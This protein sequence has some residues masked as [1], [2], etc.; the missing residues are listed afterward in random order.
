[1]DTSHAPPGAAAEEKP[2]ETRRSPARTGQR[3]SREMTATPS[4]LAGALS[5]VGSV[6]TVVGPTTIITGLLFWFGYVATAA[7]F[8]YFGLTLDL[9]NLSTPDL[10]LYGVEVIYVPIIGAF[11]GGLI[12]VL[13]HAAVTWVARKPDRDVISRWIAALAG[14]SGVMMLLR[15][16]I[17]I[18][19]PSIAMTEYPGTTPFLLALGPVLIGYGF[20]ILRLL[21]LRR[22]RLQGQDTW[23][24]TETADRCFKSLVVC[25]T[26][27][28]VAGL[29]WATN[30]FAAAYGTGRGKLQ[31]DSLPDAPEVVLET[32]D[33]LLDLPL[34]VAATETMLM[35]ADGE[36]F[37]YRYRGLRLLVESGGRL[38]LVPSPW[39]VDGSMTLAIAFDDR[40][41]VRLVP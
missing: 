9:V 23:F 3:P 12:A 39:E 20:W 21:Q 19:V 25:I 7:R 15:A 35:P 2:A 28:L 17:G 26:A 22:S 32:A 30:T 1:M 31:A 11:L 6:L 29:F 37:R 18:L 41:R 5:K 34:G 4:G 10:L 38:F 8:G 13:V 40:S 27:I 14:V 33:R 36:I 16:A 24:A